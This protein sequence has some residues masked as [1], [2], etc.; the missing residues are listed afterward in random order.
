MLQLLRNLRTEIE[1][2]EG[3]ETVITSANLAAT[4]NDTDD[5]MLSFVII[6]SPQYGEIQV[7]GSLL[8]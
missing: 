3:Q 2:K 1:V 6:K 7:R 8:L 5:H 4:D